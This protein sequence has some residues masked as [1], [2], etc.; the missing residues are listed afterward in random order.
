M[1]ALIM[2][3]QRVKTLVTPV[4]KPMRFLG[5]HL[6]VRKNP[7]RGFDCV[8]LIPKEVSHQVR[9]FIKS[10][11]RQLSKEKTLA[12]GLRGINP[13][14]RGWA[15]FYRHATGAKRVFTRMDHYVWWTIFRWLRK[16]HRR[17]SPRWLLKHYGLRMPGRRTILWKEDQITIFRMVNLRTPRFRMH[18]QQPPAFATTPMESPVQNET[19][20]PGSLPYRR[21]KRQIPDA[22]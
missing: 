18:W 3:L 20:T 2:A 12:E 6:R 11:F 19:C 9:E 1:V 21:E 13:K 22:R 14:L 4:I 15:S 10:H 17:A 16:K 7:Y 8:S 5:H